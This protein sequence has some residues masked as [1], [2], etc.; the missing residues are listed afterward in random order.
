MKALRVST[1][2]W[3]GGG[4]T[5]IHQ[6]AL[7]PRGGN[8]LRGGNFLRVGMN[9]VFSFF[10]PESMCFAEKQWRFPCKRRGL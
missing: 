2:S 4:T 3:A 1:Q 5:R 8:R 7:L 9:S 6:Q 10:I